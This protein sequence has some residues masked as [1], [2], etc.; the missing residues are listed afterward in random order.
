MPATYFESTTE[1]VDF[2]RRSG[3]L[4]AVAPRLD[5]TCSECWGATGLDDDGD[6][7]DTCYHCGRYYTE[8]RQVGRVLHWPER[9]LTAFVPITYSLDS[10]LEAL[11]HT[12][13]RQPLNRENDKRATLLGSLLRVFLAHH[14]ACIDEVAGPISHATT[15]PPRIARAFRPM[16]EILGRVS[17]PNGSDPWNLPWNHGL[18]RRVRSDKHKRGEMD[19]GFYELQAG[20]DL[21]GANVLLLDD[22]WTSGVSMASVARLLKDAGAAGVIGLTLGRQ[23]GTDNY[24]TTQYVRAVA[25]SRAWDESSCVLCG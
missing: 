20:V 1:W 16:V 22:T 13:K 19:P 5:G 18:V 24:G 14:R 12:Y 4:S 9:V 7:Y 3:L 2:A 6:P 25:E 21:T 10:G 8:F 15:V 11:L 23:L 17:G